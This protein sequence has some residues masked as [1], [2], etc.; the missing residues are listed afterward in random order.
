MK[1]GVKAFSLTEILVVIAI[2][3]LLSGLIY[4]VLINSKRH[5]L[6][7]PCTAS[8]RQLHMSWQLYTQS[9]NERGPSDLGDLYRH[10]RS[11]AVLLKCPADRWNGANSQE[12]EKLVQPISYFYWPNIDGLREALEQA[13]ANHGLFYCV[14]HGQTRAGTTTG[15][16][17]R[18][19]QGLVLRA[20]VDGSVQRAQV[21]LWC[22]APL[23]GGGILAGRTPWAL[24]TDVK[25]E[26]Q[27]CMGLDH[28]CK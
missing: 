28:P 13:D 24:L 14:T 15:N 8:L 12:T 10:D 27:W 19:L 21:G 7:V 4:P 9:N 22:S 3:A 16:P 11:I 26:G 23:K 1:Q 18:E 6:D 25:C 5:A 17:E 20:R 2:V